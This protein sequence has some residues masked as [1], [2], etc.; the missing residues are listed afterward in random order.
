MQMTHENPDLIPLPAAEILNKIKLKMAH[1]FS[2]KER[3]RLVL[4]NFINSEVLS[5]NK[6]DE[7]VKRYEL[8]YQLDLVGSLQGKILLNLDNALAQSVAAALF[9]GDAAVSDDDT[10]AAMKELL[11]IFAGH[12]ATAFN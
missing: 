11:N 5:F 7:S 12:M 3:E 6:P 8:T 1:L 4:G 9:G 2:M 10:D